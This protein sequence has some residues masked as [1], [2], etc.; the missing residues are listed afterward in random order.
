MD[1][2]I[3]NYILIKLAQK[4]TSHISKNE[5]IVSKDKSLQKRDLYSGKKY[6]YR[7]RNGN[8]WNL[9]FTLNQ[10]LP[11]CVPRTVCKGAIT[12]M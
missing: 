4:P 2:R 11:Q 3:Q 1:S 12:A 5:D 9:E 8:Q 10:Q 7:K 6:F